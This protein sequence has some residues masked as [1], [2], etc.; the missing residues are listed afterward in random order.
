LHTLEVQS[1]NT[2]EAYE[3]FDEDGRMTS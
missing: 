3:Q 2:V 1:F